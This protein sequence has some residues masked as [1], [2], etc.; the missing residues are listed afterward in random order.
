[1]TDRTLVK[2]LSAVMSQVKHIPKNGY[3]KFHKY[4]YATESDVNEKVREELAKQ[5]VVLI[6]NMKSHAVREHTTAAQK[7]EYIVTA[8][9]EFTFIDGDS[10]ETITFT[11][12]GEGQDAGD[13][14]VYKAI[15]GAQ[16]YALMKAFMIPTGDDPEADN[17][18]ESGQ[19]TPKSAQKNSTPLSGD[20]KVS[21]KTKYQMIYGSLDGIEAFVKEHGAKAE[22]VLTQQLTQQKGA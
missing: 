11:V 9:I 12:F 3:N 6:P 7:I 15:T 4:K 14:G 18:G 1:M 22:E 10:G 19:D 16:K 21:T 20:I 17:L 2:K 8:E 13:K 5:N